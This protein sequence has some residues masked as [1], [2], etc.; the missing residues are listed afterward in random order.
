MEKDV[1]QLGKKKQSVKVG[2][3]DFPLTKPSAAKQN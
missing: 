1:H 2:S 3:L